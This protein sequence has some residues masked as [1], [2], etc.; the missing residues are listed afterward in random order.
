MKGISDRKVLVWTIAGT[1]FIIFFG[2]FLHF[3]FELSGKLRPLALIAAVNE[4]T[5]E[6]LKLAFWPALIFSALEFKFLKKSVKNF[7]IAKTA[8][9]WIMPLAIIFIFYSY[10]A[11]LGEDL[12]VMDILTFI[13]AVIM[14]QIVSYR[15]LTRESLPKRWSRCAIVFFIIILLAFSILTFFP[16]HFFLFQDPISGG[17]GIID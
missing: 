16:P 7:A 9:F 3:A 10:R 15:L 17:Y 11:V 12:F 14:G 13:I 5:W 4:S 6:H 1:I 2:S 8:S